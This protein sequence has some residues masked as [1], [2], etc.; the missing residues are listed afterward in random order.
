MANR[1]ALSD[2]SAKALVHIWHTHGVKRFTSTDLH[3]LSRVR[4]SH[5]HRKGYIKRNDSTY[6]ITNSGYN[7]VKMAMQWGETGI[8]EEVVT[9]KL[10]V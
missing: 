4:L 7:Y 1:H 6:C 10:E 9:T 5:L 2:S 3:K 8:Y